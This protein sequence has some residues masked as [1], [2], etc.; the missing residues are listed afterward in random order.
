MQARISRRQDDAEAEK[1]IR[2]LREVS[3]AL[4][5]VDL[6]AGLPGEDLASFGRGFDRLH[7]LKPHEIQVGILK[8]LRGAPI[9]RHTEAHQLRYN[10]DAPYNVLATD[11]ISFNGMQRISRFARYW[12]LFG[13]AGRFRQA[14]PPLLAKV[15]PD[16]NDQEKQDIAEVALASGIDGLIVGNTT[17]GR[18][19]F[20]KDRV[21][22]KEAG[23]LSGKPLFALSTRMLAETYVRVEGAFPLVGVGGID[24]SEAALAKIRAGADVLQ[25]YSALVFK[26]LGLIA[27]I[28]RELVDALDRG[29]AP[30]LS[31]LVG[32]D[33]AAV[34]A[35]PWP[36]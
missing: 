28:K 24:S 15:G 21:T 10:P 8:R 14:L 36:N 3:P 32:A 33:A 12:D 2:W 25:L 29:D 6:I 27:E 11:C 5:H 4:I 17:I 20:L 22:S 1:N 13:N 18:P 9:D 30:A 16:L 19:P 23:G 34:T 26:G 31:D 7:A 35:E